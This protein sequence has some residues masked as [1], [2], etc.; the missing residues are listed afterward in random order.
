M[1]RGWRI[2]THE[3]RTKASYYA[4]IGNKFFPRLHD[5]A[6]FARRWVTQ[7][8]SRPL[9]KCTLHTANCSLY[10]SSPVEMMAAI[11]MKNTAATM[12]SL[13]R[14]PI[15]FFLGPKAHPRVHPSL[16]LSLVLSQ[17]RGV[18]LNCI[19]DCRLLEGHA[20]MMSTAGGGRRPGS[21]KSRLSKGGCVNFIL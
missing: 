11:G 7:P 10:S 1:V 17:R 14:R 3:F 21:L 9:Y 13:F 12:T 2:V 19:S 4:E 6:H 15:F 20:Y 5:S 16:S 18:K 8:F